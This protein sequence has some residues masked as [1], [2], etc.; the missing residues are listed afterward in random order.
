MWSASQ[1]ELR[2]LFSPAHFDADSLISLEPSLLLL[3]STP[4]LYFLVFLLLS[5]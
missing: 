5:S 4:V 1:S 3:Q 2:L